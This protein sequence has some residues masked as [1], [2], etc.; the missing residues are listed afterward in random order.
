M[1]LDFE[2]S[3]AVYS[4]KEKLFDDCKRYNYELYS[5]NGKWFRN[6]FL[7]MIPRKICTKI[8]LNQLAEVYNHPIHQD[9]KINIF[10]SG[11]VKK[12]SVSTVELPDYRIRLKSNPKVEFIIEG[13]YP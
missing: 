8:V 9:F 12:N 11:R 7:R 5:K 3:L 2:Q 4:A 6:F 10:Y 13:A 1:G